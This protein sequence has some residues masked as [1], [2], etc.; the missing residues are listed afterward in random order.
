MK[1]KLI[2]TLFLLGLI[3]YQP[4]IPSSAQVDTVEIVMDSPAKET[5]DS[6]EYN[7]LIL[8]QKLRENDVITDSIDAQHALILKQSQEIRKYIL[9]HKSPV[10][11]IESSIDSPRRTGF[12]KRIF[13][14]FK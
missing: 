6:F 12:F 3:I 13:R 9:A 11:V 2:F 7:K 5:V 1:S 8:D 10:V 4:E 14:I